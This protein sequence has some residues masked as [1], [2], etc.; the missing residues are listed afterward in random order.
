MIGHFYGASEVCLWIDFS[1]FTI[2]KASAQT[3]LCLHPDEL[4]T[5]CK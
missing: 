4:H 1:F 2:L 5:V 3:F